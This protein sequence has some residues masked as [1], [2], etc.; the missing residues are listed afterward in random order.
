MNDGLTS[1]GGPAIDPAALVENAIRHA[2]GRNF[3]AGRICI[4]AA[5]V[6]GRV[7]GKVQDDGARAGDKCD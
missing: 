5:T 3:S 1:S 6:D 2:I 4:R 7:E